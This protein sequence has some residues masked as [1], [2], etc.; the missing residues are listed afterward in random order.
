LAVAAFL[1][2]LSPD[3]RDAQ[4]LAAAVLLLLAVYAT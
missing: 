2:P 1:A 4:T 3:V